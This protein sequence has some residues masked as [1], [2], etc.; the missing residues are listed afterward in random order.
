[1]SSLSNSGVLGVL[2][3]CELSPVRLKTSWGVRQQR[4]ASCPRRCLTLRGRCRSPA[5]IVDAVAE[6]F[7]CTWPVGFANSCAQ[8]VVK[9]LEKLSPCASLSVSL[10][11]DPSRV[12][13]SG[14]IAPCVPVEGLSESVVHKFCFP[15]FLS[16]DQGRQSAPYSGD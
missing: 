13:R 1:L 16:R 12:S 7:L 14:R 11:A 10:L 2:F 9:A 6:D 4:V 5:R 15:G 3:R 8:C